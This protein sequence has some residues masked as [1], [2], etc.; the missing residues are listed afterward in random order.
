MGDFKGGLL[1]VIKFHRVSKIALRERVRERE[2]D[3]ERERKGVRFL[4]SKFRKI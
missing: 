3:R 2:R 4:G 1:R